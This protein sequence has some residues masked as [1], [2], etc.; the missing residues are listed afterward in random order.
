MTWLW[1]DDLARL[2]VEHDGVSPERLVRW[3]MQP[4][5]L[6]AADGEPLQQARRLLDEEDDDHQPAAA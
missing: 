1:T 5:A 6:R 3:V 4:V 2:L